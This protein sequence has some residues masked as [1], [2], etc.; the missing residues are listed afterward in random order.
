MRKFRLLTLL[1]LAFAFIAVN[2]T[3]EGPEGPAGATGPQGPSGVTGPAGPTGPNGPTGPAGP[4][5]PQGAPGTANVIYGAWTTEPANWGADT[6]MT[7][8]N[9]GNAKRFIVSSPGI[10]QAMLDQG[11]ILSY[12]RGGLTNQLPVQIPYYVPNPVPANNTMIDSRPAL[13]KIVYIFWM[14]AN[15]Y[16]PIVATNLNSGGQFRYILIPGSV[17]GRIAGEKMATINGRTYSQAQLQAMSYS[18]VCS[19]FRIQP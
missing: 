19:L 6:V 18:Q 13:G 5:G 11:V 15:P 4:T 7:S 8:L 16:I 14:I 2:C 9:G 1:L 12:F 10:N 17:A 3:K